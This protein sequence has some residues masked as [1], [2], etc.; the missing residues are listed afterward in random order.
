[1]NS[2]NQILYSSLAALSLLGTACSGG[3][4]DADSASMS[5]A[6]ASSIPDSG[7]K[8]QSVTVMELHP[9]NFYHE[10][11]S[12]GKLESAGK[13]D[14]NFEQN[15]V[16]AE[17]LVRNGQHVAKGQPLARLDCTKL[18][19]SRDR[20]RTAVAQ[21]QLELKDVL[22]GQGYDPER[23]DEVPAE[24]MRLAR[25]RSGL[26][27]A[28]LSL[29]STE[30]DLAKATLKAPISGLVA[31]LTTQPH[32]MV[33]MSEP[34]CT[35]IDNGALR[36][37]FNVLES[38]LP[39]VKPGDPVE[40]APYSSAEA[41][42]GRITEI[43]PTIDENGMVK[44]WA[45]VE[46]NSALLDGMNVRVTVKRLLERSLVV[47]K[48]AVVLRTGRQVVFTLVDG[49]AFWNYVTTG[50]ENL[51]EYTIVEGLKEG[52]N[53]IITGNENLAHEAEV[54]VEREQGD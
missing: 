37:G 43:N 5:S 39:L 18:E 34:F 6:P 2:I 29:A 13:V 40:I 17:I 28:E 20:E 21:A 49:K 35:I 9:A 33:N 32:N 30:R 14:V 26:E 27:Q 46:G 44:V 47:P 1:M 41:T 36:V 42:R 50:L 45:N 4:G 24:I 7:D 31:N 23:L 54:K 10:V 3:N 48:T 53:V 8:I 51:N 16:I 52:D 19:N 38:E 15:E 25:L 22:I 11:V 12:N